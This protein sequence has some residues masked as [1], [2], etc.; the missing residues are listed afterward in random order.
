V[1]CSICSRQLKPFAST[2]V[3]A[4]VARMRGSSTRSAAEA[5]VRPTLEVILTEPPAHLVK[6]HDP[7]SG[8]ALIRPDITAV[9]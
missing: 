2:S 9:A 6:A 5:H 8:L 3:S 4:A 1:H 7:E